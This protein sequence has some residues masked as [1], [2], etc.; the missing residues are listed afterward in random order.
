MFVP[1]HYVT[2]NCFTLNTIEHIMAF[3]TRMIIYL[4]T[5]TMHIV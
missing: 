5:P 4:L 3:I 2:L 1:D